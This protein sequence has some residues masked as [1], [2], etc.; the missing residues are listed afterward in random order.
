MFKKK[1]EREDI[2]HPVT[3]ERSLY[4]IWAQSQYHRGINEMETHLD[5]DQERD[6]DSEH[7]EALE[8]LG[9]PNL[10]SDL[11]WAGLWRSDFDGERDPYCHSSTLHIN[12]FVFSET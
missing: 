11:T 2:E 7:L 3:V 4:L 10:L 8:W 5:L 12:L 9:E 1:Q 6:L